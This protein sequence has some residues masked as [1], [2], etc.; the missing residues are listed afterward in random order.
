VSAPLDRDAALAV[1]CALVVD[2]A[3]GDLNAPI[4]SCPGW[5]LRDA[6]Y[7]CGQVLTLWA[8][9]LIGHVD[10]IKEIAFPAPPPDDKLIDW[11]ETLGPELSAAV[12]EADPQEQFWTFWGPQPG[13]WF[14][15]RALQEL[16]IHRVDTQSATGA[17]SPIEPVVAADGI[18]ER[19][20][21]FGFFQPTGTVHL[22]CTDV[23][24][25]WL[26]TPGEMKVTVV[27]EH[28]KGD[29]AIRGRA[30]DILLTLWRRRPLS[31]VEVLGNRD[32]VEQWINTG[33]A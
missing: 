7:H 32:L 1:E 3:R 19:L 12:R 20:D 6:V 23:Q 15:R 2:A 18:D 10:S 26:V 4:A 31:T 30:E 11:F 8:Q 29:A 24:G 9:A 28:A 14:L 33:A 27:R 5:T 22:H 16:V 25:E 21:V 17:F 13:E